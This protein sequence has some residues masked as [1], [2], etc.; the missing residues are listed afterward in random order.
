MCCSSQALTVQFIVA[1]HLPAEY[2]TPLLDY[3][4]QT[5]K[6]GCDFGQFSL[7][8][9]QCRFWALTGSRFI[10]KVWVVSAGDSARICFPAVLYTLYPP[11]SDVV[12]LFVLP[13]RIHFPWPRRC[14]HCKTQQ[15]T[16]LASWTTTART[17][18]LTKPAPYLPL[19]PTQLAQL[20]P[21][22][23]QLTAPT[24]LSFEIIEAR[25]RCQHCS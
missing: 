10:D 8:Q 5:K 21:L 2:F 18:S 19:Q 13:H 6:V 12:L 7:L 1:H 22:L 9:T 15:L 4:S 23:R 25:T 11:A 14:L 24:A 20:A 3:I 17:Q 16:W